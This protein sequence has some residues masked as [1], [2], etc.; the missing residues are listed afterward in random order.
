[1][2]SDHLSA[3]LRFKIVKLQYFGSIS[4]FYF[5]VSVTRKYIDTFFMNATCKLVRS[6]RVLKLFEV[7]LLLKASF[8]PKQFPVYLL[9]F[10][11]LLGNSG[12]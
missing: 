8:V 7:K 11:S 4:D 10:S 5:S 9:L 12:R 3:E 6:M 1:M 2:F